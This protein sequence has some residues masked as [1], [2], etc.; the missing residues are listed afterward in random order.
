[1]KFIVSWLQ[2][3]PKHVNHNKSW[4]RDFVAK[5]S[6]RFFSLFFVFSILYLC[7]FSSIF[8]NPRLFVLL[9]LLQAGMLYIT[10]T[11]KYPSSKIFKLYKNKNNRIPIS[12]MFV[13]YLSLIVGVFDWDYLYIFLFCRFTWKIKRS[14]FWTVII[15]SIREQQ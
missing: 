15:L 9:L 11:I 2:Q 7:F 14:Q 4:E 13:L 12:S 6:W 10:Y 1:L 5:I 8:L 3:K